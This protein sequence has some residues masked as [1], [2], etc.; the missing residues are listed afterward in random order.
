MKTHAGQKDFQCDQCEKNFFTTR[1]LREHKIST[2]ERLRF[3]CDSPN[4]NG[5]FS[6]YNSHVVII[7]QNFIF[8]ILQILHL[9]NRREYYKKH[10][11]AQHQDLGP[12]GLE[13]LMRKVRAAVPVRKFE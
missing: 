3:I 1:S 13:E 11:Q 12:E 6:R 4:C 7:L 9:I 10:V 2:H 8:I 5:S